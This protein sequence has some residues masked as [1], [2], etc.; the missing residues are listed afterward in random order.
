MKNKGACKEYERDEYM[1]KFEMS[2]EYRGSGASK[3]LQRGLLAYHEGEQIVNEGMGIGICAIQAGG[4]T[5]FSTIEEI[6][7]KAGSVRVSYKIDNVLTRSIFGVKSRLLTRILEYFT[8]SIYMKSE[9]IQDSL[10]TAGDFLRG[11]LSIETTFEK[12]ACM[13][14][15]DVVYTIGEFDVNV[16]VSCDS[17]AE[18]SK[19]FVMNELGGSVFKEAEN[20]GVVCRPPSGWQRFVEGSRLYSPERKISFTIREKSVPEGV[21]SSLY[22][23]REIARGYN[24]AGFESMLIAENGI[25][26]GYEYKIEFKRTGDKH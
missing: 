26:D 18:N 25:V 6:E 9:K 4:L 8:T 23:G 16:S 5:Y 12:S 10:L 2:K 1:I 20:N 21:K 24:W 13:A 3:G 19:I 22:W 11:A 14:N 17:K 7:M 15:V